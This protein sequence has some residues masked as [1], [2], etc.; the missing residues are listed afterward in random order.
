LVGTA[1]P[2]STSAQRAPTTD[3]IPLNHETLAQML[4]IR[5]TTVTMVAGTL[6][7]DAVIICGRGF[8]QIFVS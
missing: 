6:E 8:M 2:T 1:S 3:K 4:T 7:K 5:P